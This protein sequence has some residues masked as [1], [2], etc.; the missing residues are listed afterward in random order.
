MAELPKAPIIRIIKS[1]GENVR[2]S[3]DAEDKIVEAVEQY[4]KNFGTV[5]I[6][7]SKHTSRKTIQLDDVDLVLKHFN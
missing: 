6:D 5:I 3:K 4:I 1:C 7:V 2:I